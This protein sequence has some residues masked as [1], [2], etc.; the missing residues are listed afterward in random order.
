MTGKRVNSV[1]GN[2]GGHKSFMNQMTYTKGAL[3]HIVTCLVQFK[4]RCVCPLSLLFIYLG[5][6]EHC[7]SNSGVDQTT[8]QRPLGLGPLPTE[9]CCL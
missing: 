2:K 4:Q 1:E 5:C 7:H 9:L 6:S 3:T 8:L